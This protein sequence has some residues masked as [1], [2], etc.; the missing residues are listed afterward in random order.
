MAKKEVSQEKTLMVPE[1]KITQDAKINYTELEK[2]TSSRVAV[3][4][5]NEYIRQKGLTDRINVNEFAF[6][7]ILNRANRVM[8]ITSHSAGG[9]DATI[10]DPRLIFGQALKM[11]ASALIL[12]HNHPSGTLTPSD[13]EKSIS[14]RI[15]TAGDMLGISVLDF[16]IIT[17][18]NG[19]H[20]FSDNGDMTRNTFAK[21]G[22]VSGKLFAPKGFVFTTLGSHRASDK[23]KRMGVDYVSLYSFTTGSGSAG[24]S[25]VMLKKT[26]YEKLKGIKGVGNAKESLPSNHHWFSREENSRYKAVFDKHRD[27]FAPDPK[28]SVDYSDFYKSG[29]VTKMPLVDKDNIRKIDKESIELLTSY[30]NE[31]P[32]TKTFH[33]DEKTGQYSKERKRLH[34][35]IINKYKKEVVCITESQPIAILMGGSPASGKSSFLKK[36]SPYLLQEEIL[37]VDA[38]EIRAKLPEYK[39][40]N[41]S[42]TQQET[43]DIVNTL[44]SDKVV[45]I[46]CDFDMIYDGT[47]NN[48]KGY[49]PL[50]DMLKKRGY[51][52]FIAYIDN[53][54]KDVIIDRL[55]KRYQKTGRFVPIE[56]VDDFFS[57]GKTAFNELKDKVDGY[58]IVDGSNSE[59]EVIERGGKELPKDR[60]YSMLGY[61]IPEHMLPKEYR[62]GGTIDDK[63]AKLF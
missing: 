44:L 40:W 56:V 3:T 23:V 59:Y 63:Q 41:A 33:F 8:G 62:D 52:V 43:K 10:I 50:I 15:N 53:V 37:R 5:L 49:I 24:S 2:V 61:P 12:A 54:P 45:G 21:G 13:A 47:M 29:G 25:V 55:L 1:Y 36:Y 38:D 26:D 17:A 19:Y 34:A 6:V 31:L 30:V 58:M 16:M 39:G 9:M 11:G 18:S 27:K 28:S 60:A 57:K 35:E 14:K 4:I 46:P 22:V 42:Q 20:S 51:M 7:L 32:Q 48:V